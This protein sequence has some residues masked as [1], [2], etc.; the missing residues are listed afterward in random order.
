MAKANAV[1]PDNI[2]HKRSECMER[3]K[4]IKR[5]MYEMIAV[6]TAL[7]FL[8]L[9]VF[10]LRPSSIV[11]LAAIYLPMVLIFNVLFLRRKMSSIGPVATEERAKPRP[12]RFSLFA[13]SAIFF[14]GTLLGLMKILHGELPLTILP[15]LL[16]PLAV[17]VYC[18]KLA[19]RSDSEI[20]TGKSG[21][22]T[23]S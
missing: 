6:D 17:A 16:V 13:C 5:T 15:F 14:V 1:R 20:Q 10:F 3:R 8:L 12:R 21:A 7:L 19:L 2:L 18:L 22:K 9:A 11:I 4:R 23:R